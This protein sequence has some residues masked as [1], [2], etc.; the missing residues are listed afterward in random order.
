MAQVI[1]RHATVL[2]PESVGPVQYNPLAV[3]LP[4]GGAHGV[5]A[6]APDG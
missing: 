1:A 6:D 5:G 2:V 4:M 3:S